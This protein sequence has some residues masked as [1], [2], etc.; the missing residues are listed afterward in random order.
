MNRILVSLLGL[1]WILSGCATTN[2]GQSSRILAHSK[3]VAMGSSFAAGAGIGPIQ[4][5]SPERCSRTVNNYASLVASALKL[6]LV[7]VSCSGASTDHILG[8][9]NELPPQI[10]SVGP[11]TRLVTVTIGGNDLRYV[12]WLF[13]SSCRLGVSAYPGPCRDVVA[14]SDADYVRLEEQLQK[15]ATEIRRRAPQ[16]RVFFVQY[17]TLL[18]DPT[19]PLETIAPED[20]IVGRQIASRLAR[21]TAEV[22]RAN[23][24]Y[25]IQAD[26][27]SR[28]HTP[29]AAEPWSNGLS[30]GYDTKNGAPWHPNAAGHEAISKMLIKSM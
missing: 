8:S 30:K 2:G 6:D 1:F 5:G 20:A 9:W 7:D 19:C 27:A 23:G 17:V 28:Y 18:S 16:A 26:I 22:A 25:T 15:M 24:I 11:D 3:Y 29:C 10:E 12:G 13:A 4:T 14:P 21:I